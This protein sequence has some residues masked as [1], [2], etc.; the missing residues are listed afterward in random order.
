MALDFP[1]SP[2][3][4]QTYSASGGTWIYNGNSWVNINT[5][6]AADIVNILGYTPVPTSRTL[7]INGTA[8]DLSANRSWTINASQWT[9]SGSNIFY[10]TGNVGIGTSTPNSATNYSTLSVNGS[11]GGQ[12]TWQTGGSLIGYAYNTVNGLVLGANT[13]KILVFDAGATER[14]RIT[15]AGN[16]GIGT[17]A[18][19]TAL[20]VNGTITAGTG[21]NLRLSSN[22]TEGELVAAF[23]KG[24]RFYTNDGN[25][26]PMNLTSAGNVGIGTTSPNQKLHISGITKIA[27]STPSSSAV[28]TLI[29]SND[30]DNDNAITHTSD[31]ALGFLTN[32][33]ERMRIT[34]GGN[35]GIGTTS[36]ESLLHLSQAS[37]G[38]NGAFIFIDNPAASTLGNTA[39]IRFATDTG[40]SFSGYAGYLECV[41]AN[42][43]NGAADLRFGTWNGSSRGER[44]R[45]SFGGSLCVNTAGGPVINN[46]TLST[47]CLLYT[48]P[49]PRDRQKSRMPSSA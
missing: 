44:V 10:N 34:S 46:T 41:N 7:S 22:S 5:L 47:S 31:K 45:I 19:A 40:G 18:P 35:V 25:S 21:G 38:G 9:T 20:H 17:T 16:V 39:G 48:S 13:D 37:T 26:N 42:A 2:T 28:A 15:S 1:S 14:M 8:F 3:I 27:P 23:G 33:S 30:F 11:S 29:L 24:L 12:I 49:S 32:G 43:G 6:T 4:G 36:P